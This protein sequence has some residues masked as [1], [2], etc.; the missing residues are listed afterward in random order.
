MRRQ[1]QQQR[2]ASTSRRTATAITTLV[3]LGCAS[4]AAA[5][6]CTAFDEAGQAYVFGASYGD[7]RLGSIE[8][9]GST[10]S[11]ASAAITSL[12]NKTGRPDFSG[13]NTQCF[14]N[15]F[16][17]GLYVINAVASS[18]NDVYIY[19]FEGQAWS[20]QPT[21]GAPNASVAILDHDTN[22]LFAFANGGLTSLSFNQESA[23]STGQ[24]I[25]WQAG[26]QVNDVPF[27][28]TG[29]QPV[30][31]AANNHIQFLNTPGSNPGEAYIFVI[32]YAYWQPEVQS[33]GTFPVSPGQTVTVLSNSSA[34]P[35]KFAYIPDSGN[36]TYVIDAKSNTTAAYPAPPT[37]DL[38]ARYSASTQVLLQLAPGG[39]LAYLDLSASGDN[40]TTTSWTSVALP[41]DILALNGTV[42]T[43]NNTA[44]TA[45]A[46]GQV[47]TQ[48]TS[49][50][51][52]GGGTPPSDKITGSAASLILGGEGR[53]DL[54]GLGS[55]FA[56][57]A[58]LATL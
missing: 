40:G 9:F 16:T 27:N 4:Y 33:F 35:S 54:L 22:V 45:N 5:S 3:V 56:A 29:Y 46:G 36:E 23:K 41:S 28:A 7:L 57:L 32:H 21:S 19:D 25:S 44:I 38:G 20:T 30:M 43:G 34:A 51:Q 26:A 53:V 1:Q 14:T 52:S 58:I 47:S 37:A 6:Q 31:G 55:L 17:N 49:G 11:N 24:T 12:T 39:A 13:S 18:P 50:F 10:A 42:S 8:E 48:G 2:A 15:Q